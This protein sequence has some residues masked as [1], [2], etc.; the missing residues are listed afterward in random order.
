MNKMISNPNWRANTGIRN[1]NSV[2]RQPAVCTSHLRVPS[3]FSEK[4][5]PKSDVETSEMS[6][7][8][9]GGNKLRLGTL[10]KDVNQRFIKS[11]ESQYAQCNKKFSTIAL[12]LADVYIKGKRVPQNL[13]R[14][15]EILSDSA[16][17]ESKYML[18][19]LAYDTHN[20]ADAFHYLEFFSCSKCNCFEPKTRQ[21]KKLIKGRGAPK[22]PNYTVVA[23][24]HAK[25]H[26]F[27][28]L[29]DAIKAQIFEFLGAKE[30]TKRYKEGSSLYFKA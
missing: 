26:C 4:S 10:L 28:H 7:L 23:V 12:Q 22:Y 3:D 1:E 19:K 17:A 21:P 6:K 5:L 29:C 20:Y 27:K 30:A 2:V 11:L 16:L 15:V 14:A 13:S 24:E 18:V 25:P 8:I 9:E